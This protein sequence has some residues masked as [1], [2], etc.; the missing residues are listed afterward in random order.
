MGKFVELAYNDIDDIVGYLDENPDYCNDILNIFEESNGSIKDLKSSMKG[1]R[2]LQGGTYFGYYRED[3]LQGLFLFT[4]KN[5]LVFYY[6]NRS[7]L[8]KVGVLLEI[9]KRKPKYIKGVSEQVDDLY[10]IIHKTVDLDK[11]NLCYFMS[12]NDCNKDSLEINDNIKSINEYKEIKNIDFFVEVEN[13]FDRNYYSINDLR[14]KLVDSRDTNYLVYSSNDRIVGQGLIEKQ[15]S[16]F[17][18]IGGLYVQTSM[19]GKGIG[20]EILARILE[21]LCDKEITPILIVKKDNDNAIALYRNYGF[22]E[23]YDYSVYELSY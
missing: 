21:K 11:S 3:A 2:K 4:N 14:K 19:R 5:S 18:Q 20:K 6:S 7:V 22:V 9:K 1:N 16:Y 17:A 23:K 13:K 15:N 12:L 10:K 8:N